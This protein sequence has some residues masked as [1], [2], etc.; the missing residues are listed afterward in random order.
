MATSQK[1]AGSAPSSQGTRKQSSWNPFDKPSSA[2]AGQAKLSNPADIKAAVSG[3]D[4]NKSYYTSTAPSINA[5][6]GGGALK[7]IDEKFQVNPATGTCSLSIPFGVPPGRG[8]LTPELSLS[9]DSGSGNGPF[10][11]G[12]ALSLASITRKT[13]KGLPQYRDD[14]D[15]DVYLLSGMEDLVPKLS[16]TPGAS[17]SQGDWVMHQYWP[18]TEGAFTRIE[19]WTKPSQPTETYWR[20]I[21]G[22]NVTSLY[23]QTNNS[24]ILDQ[25]DGR[26]F[27]WLLCASY[28]SR[29]NA[30]QYSYK[31]E[32]S[33][34]VRLDQAHERHRTDRSRAVNRYIKSIKYGNVTPNRDANWNVAPVPDDGW[35]FEAVFDYGDH[36]KDNPTSKPD[37]LWTVRKDAFSTYTAG[38]EI[39]TYR[40][41][42]R[43]LLFHHFKELPVTDYL[44][45]SMELSYSE[46][47]A[48][49]VLASAVQSGHA[50]NSSEPV[51]RSLPPIKFGYSTVDLTRTSSE[52][53]SSSALQN[54]P[55]GLSSPLQWVDLDGVG[56]ASP[57]LASG[58]GW[59]HMKNLST[60]KSDYHNPSSGTGDVVFGPPQ[61]LLRAPNAG[62]DGKTALLDLDGNGR[63]DVVRTEL[64]RQGFYERTD[65]GGWTE[66]RAFASWPSVDQEDPNLRYLDLTGN[67]LADIVI[68]Q[69]DNFLWFPALGTEGYGEGRRAFAGSSEDDGPRLL[70]S[71]GLETIY[72]ADFSGDGLVDLVRIRNGDVCY[73]PNIGYGRFGAK[74]SMDNA[75]WMDPVD[76]YNKNRIQLADVDGSG[77]A[78]ILYFPPAGGLKVYLNL[79]GNGWGDAVEVG[80]PMLDSLS[81]VGILD[82]FGLGVS[83]VVWSS[84]L[85]GSMHTSLQYLDFTQGCKPYLLTAYSN[86]PVETRMDYTSSAMFHQTD[87][88]AGRCWPGQLPFPVQCLTEVK[89]YD[90]ISRAFSQTSY[91][92]HDGYF[93]GLEREFRGFGKV[94]STNSECFL[95]ERSSRSFPSPNEAK[96]LA[97]PPTLNVAWYHTGAYESAKRARDLYRT[98]PQDVRD[99][100]R[101][102]KGTSVHSEI[103]LLDGSDKA[104]IPFVINDNTVSV[105]L[106]QPMADTKPGVF[107]V[108]QRESIICQVERNDADPRINHNVTL[109]VD[110]WG[111][112][113]K[114]AAIT[115]G[116]RSS[117]RT[118]TH[119]GDD[120]EAQGSVHITYTEQDFTNFVSTVDDFYTPVAAEARIYDVQGLSPNSTLFAFD[121]LSV[122]KIRNLPTKAYTNESD[123]AGLRL[124]SRTQ[125]R[126]RANDL[127]KTLDPGVMESMAI[128]GEQYTLAIT[129]DVFQTAF[130][131][132]QTDALLSSTAM[133]GDKTGSGGGYVELEPDSWWIPA[134][135]QRFTQDKGASS[136]DELKTA[137]ASFFQPT[138]FIDPFGQWQHATYDNYFMFPVTVV[139]ALGNTRR[140]VMD[141]RTLQP[142]LVT[143]ENGNQS[144]FAFDELGQ[145]VGVAIMEKPGAPS[146]DTLDGFR[147]FLD[148]AT[149][150]E[151]ASN[152]LGLAQTLLVGCS[153]FSFSDLPSFSDEN[154]WSPAFNITVARDTSVAK[155]Q[156]AIS[157]GNLRVTLAYFDG[158]GQP[159]Q[160]RTL[161]RNGSG[162][163]QWVVRGCKV[164]NNSGALVRQYDDFLDGSHQ[165]SKPTGDTYMTN[166]YDPIGRLVATVLPN[167]T[168]AKTVYGSWLHSTYDPGDTVLVENPRADP[169]VGGYLACLEDSST[170]LPTWYSRMST[171]DDAVNRRSAQLSKQYADTPAIIWLDVL[172]QPFLQISDNGDGGKYERLVGTSD[173]DMVG[174]CI[175]TRSMDTGEVHLLNDVTGK[176]LCSWN[177]RGIQKSTSYDMLRR[178]VS[179][180]IR[181]ADGIEF[182]DQKVVYG[183]DQPQPESNNLRGKAYQVSDQAL[184][185]T[186][187][188]YDH[189]GNAIAGSQQLVKEYKNTVDWSGSVELED[190]KFTYSSTFNTLGG[191]LTHTRTDGSLVTRTYNQQGQLSSLQATGNPSASGTIIK[192]IRYDAR[193]QRAGIS[194]GNGTECRFEYDPKTFAISSKSLMRG[195]TALQHLRYARDCLGRITRIDDLAQQDIF[196]RGD[197][198]KPTKEFTYDAVGR[199]T[200]ATGREHL[201]QV[202]QN[203]ISIPSSASAGSREDSPS[204]GK[205]MANYVEEYTYSPEGNILSAVHSLP[206]SSVPGWNRTYQ[207]TEP[208]LLEDSKHSN[209]LSSTTVGKIGS[210]YKYEDV[211]GKSGLMTSMSGFPVLGYDVYERLS[212]S[213]RQVVS[214][215]NET[216]PEM[217]YY[218]YDSNNQRVRKVT[219]KFAGFGEK[220]VRMKDHLYVNGGQIEIF[221][222]FDRTNATAAASERWSWHVS[223][224]DCR[225]ALVEADK[226]I[227]QD[228]KDD[229]DN[230]AFAN[231]VSRYMAD[232]HV[233]SVSLELDDEGTVISMEEFSPYGATTYNAAT[234]SSLKIPKRY[235]FAAKERDNE[236]GFCYFENRYLL[237]WLGRWLSPDPIG[238]A[239]GLNVYCYVSSD[240]VN[241]VDPSGLGM[242]VFVQLDPEHKNVFALKD[243]ELAL[244]TLKSDDPTFI[245]AFHDIVLH[246]DFFQNF[247]EGCNAFMRTS[248]GLTHARNINKVAHAE[249]V[250]LKKDSRD[251]VPVSSMFITLEPCHSKRYAGHCCLE[252]FKPDGYENP[253][254]DNKRQKFEPQA[255]VTPIFFMEQQTEKDLASWACRW[256]RRV[257]LYEYLASVWSEDILNANPT[258]HPM[259][260]LGYDPERDF[261]PK[262]FVKR[263]DDKGEASIFLALAHRLDAVRKKFPGWK[264]EDLQE[265]HGDAIRAHQLALESRPVVVG[266][267]EDWK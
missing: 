212:A 30:V 114:S 250:L 82:L 56:K 53:A 219:E 186:T 46:S 191:L 115:Y 45:K 70:F 32:D 31:E 247:R 165:F 163:E 11:L 2:Q 111:N 7:S 173:F 65:E 16:E 57:I 78:D 228:G 9:Y 146:R 205:A 67:G 18:R 168:W 224:D 182:T 245:H 103:Y 180:R 161:N 181:T 199:L 196:F 150:R 28:D 95:L 81:S 171:S 164:I 98:D 110:D 73:W 121:E 233:S 249:D 123:A 117:F 240:P 71:D 253:F 60:Y 142:S 14:V 203:W 52:C 101:A 225:V 193:G 25:S 35:L 83:S 260:R 218:R 246:R 267:V 92:Y 200:K 128:S 229:G 238:T 156:G 206:N 137:R 24:R 120:W 170:L 118:S 259:A 79:A 8:G 63:L 48:V 75:P 89:T 185:S 108:S 40:L 41:C 209:R 242:F 6:T 147:P 88:L 230:R 17:N 190:E 144:A 138:T 126:Y 127:S 4:S 210:T 135:Q 76:R 237:P 50:L 107:L 133:L 34:G 169:D 15:S 36:A 254:N 223:S 91:T 104:G 43:L 72:L 152:P 154:G 22:T 44:V 184:V 167:H 116:R 100:Y 80:F 20:T 122:S 178:P 97:C 105:K 256:G 241:N 139:D 183:E 148:P 23:G 132:S 202:G 244:T 158:R 39:R 208:S 134:G 220:P 166:F 42:R 263:L 38:F 262:T 26:V 153:T 215:D 62:D 207:Y 113:T 140:S 197:V 59:F 130:Q 257:E 258:V 192:E 145:V 68:S 49:S 55:T 231:A 94:E 109:E 37:T 201:G 61:A 106:L 27:A 112:T 74:V 176:H 102:L 236:T 87:E 3:E 198:V 195:K 29:G 119:T 162:P 54:L 216:T 174:T 211:S 227:S 232:D 84:T 221:R 129:Q 188:R 266:T 189:L 226:T 261:I 33:T 159:L 177:S 21:T 85:P 204:D 12:W 58:E 239:G 86:G 149:L 13:S 10:G 47:G 235:R 131:A 255:D 64:G 222:K 141:Y 265:A 179:S 214:G 69:A 151:L 155:L 99:A 93:D 187:E 234:A 175:R 51:T 251:A 213:S 19:K 136:H 143:D 5:P 252:Y 157:L 125:T 90:Y 1:T 217:T 194:Y 172:G 77:V 160:A 66:F 248:A 124:I 96:G 243:G 264:F